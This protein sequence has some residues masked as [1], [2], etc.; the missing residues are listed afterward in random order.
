MAETQRLGAA[1]EKSS[2]I[3]LLL[4]FLAVACMATA[5]YWYR[6]GERRDRAA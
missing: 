6:P 5:R 2:K 1:I 3:D 4:L